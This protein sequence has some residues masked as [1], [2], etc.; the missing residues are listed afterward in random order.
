[1]TPSIRVALAALALAAS[2]FASAKPQLVA[3][4]PAQGQQLDAPPIEIRLTFSERVD[5]RRASIK[6]VSA[7]G[8]RFDADRPHADKADP[9]TIA[10]SVPVLRRG[11]WRARWTAV[12]A[13]GRKVHGDVQ[14]SIK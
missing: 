3:V 13:D 14:F 12:G 7:E 6:L 4:S 2:P 9:L 1:M 8:K 11:A 10:A 5:A